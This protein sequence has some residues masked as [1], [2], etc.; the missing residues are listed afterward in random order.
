VETDTIG[1][2]R[3]V[4]REP[5]FPFIELPE[6]TRLLKSAA[7]D[8]GNA[9]AVKSTSTNAIAPAVLYDIIYPTSFL[10]DN[11]IPLDKYFFTPEVIQISLPA[12]RDLYAFTLHF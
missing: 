5:I 2:E 6:F 1:A 4:A 10:L 9:M 7:A 12:L 8:A 11:L 3:L